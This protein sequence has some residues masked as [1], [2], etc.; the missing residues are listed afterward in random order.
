MAL[1]HNPKPTQ[2][3]VISTHLREIHCLVFAELIDKKMFDD[4]TSKQLV[5]IFSCFTNISVQDDLKAFFPKPD[6]KI[7]QNVNFFNLFIK[8]HA[9]L[10][11]YNRI[12]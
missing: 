10:C 5:A 9:N 6:N 7:I 3:G 8:L 12:T 4:L 11:K 2:K 1:D